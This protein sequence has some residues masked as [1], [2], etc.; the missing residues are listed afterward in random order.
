MNENENPYGLTRTEVS[1]SEIKNLVYSFYDKV[2]EDAE[3]APVFNDVIQDNWTQHLEKMCDFWSSAMLMTNR[4]HGNPMLKHMQVKTI[5]PRHFERW[6]ELFR[7]ATKE[8]LTDDVAKQFD[9]RAERIAEA[10]QS[11][12]FE[13]HV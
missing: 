13:G 3:L 12:L 10:L 4:Y 11:R 2:R 1:E 9:A 8:V 6:L 5:K 7:E